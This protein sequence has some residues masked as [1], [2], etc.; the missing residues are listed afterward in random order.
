MTATPSTSAASPSAARP[1][2]V[3]HFGRFQLLRLVGKSAR[4][5]VWLVDDPRVGQ[6][7]LLAMPRTRP[8]NEGALELWRQ[9]ARRATRTDHPSLAHVVEVGE[10]DH[11]PFIAYELGLATM[12]SDRLD[13]KGIPGQ[14]SVPWML[15]VLQGLAFAHEGGVAHHDIQPYMV[16]VPP[17]GP[18]RLLGLGVALDPA[19]RNG[20]SPAAHRL[21]SERDLLAV[22][23]VMHHVLAGMPALD[24]PDV[25]QVI[26]HLPP[27]GREIVRLPWS[28]SH[29]VPEALRAIVNRAT[30]RQ[31]RQRY[32]N[33]RT[34]AR[35]LEG[36]VRSD[37]EQG[38]GPLALLQDRMRLHGLLPAMPGAGQCS[39]RLAKMERERNDEMANLVLQDL[40]LC[41]ELMRM[42]NSAQVAG[43]SGNGPILTV[44]RTIDMLGL[45][46]VRRATN[47]L[48]PWPGP[49]NEGHA[50]R[51]ERL[52]EQVR[53]AGQIAQWL[54]PAGY[55]PE[56]VYL[57]ATLQNL[58][59]LV[60]RYHFP[61][62]AAQIDHL[63]KPA[64][65]EQAGE[66]E[67]PGMTEEAASFAVLGIDI[68]AVAMAIGR[69][70][71]L[72]DAVLHMIQR[73][74]MNVAVRVTESDDEAL[75]LTASCAN[76]V[77]DATAQAAHHV[78]SSLQKV[79]QRYG[80]VLG[81]SLR[82]LQM[83]AQGQ[84]PEPKSPQE[85][86]ATNF[87]PL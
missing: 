83:V 43:T 86:R 32:H 75:R 5:M 46:G 63:M 12:L 13:S 7:L 26:D 17:T 22:G 65:A 4:T 67:Q 20:A 50:A 73:A 54:R 35:A 84:A 16:L 34:V 41:F 52:I 60:L 49:L 36:W 48:R 53:R 57:L 9:A 77:V 19:Q 51:L 58:G 24:Q 80:R 23:L 44:R 8:A 76:E 15:D 28:T 37:V 18:A 55:D 70:W 14:E 59:R 25:A 68:H 81:V 1:Q 62:E 6:E 42:V 85:A 27:L 45:D 87:T 33:A 10:H 61:D 56:L 74:P 29:P 11:W 71:G 40:A 47:A 79:V 30:D 69:Q 31:E 78:L 3:R 21:A 82:D 2:A 66:P 64:A 38:G 72:D 39:A